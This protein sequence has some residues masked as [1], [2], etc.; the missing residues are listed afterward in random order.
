MLRWSRADD[1][2]A[3]GAVPR[4]TGSRRKGQAAEELTTP[5]K[6]CPHDTIPPISAE[7]WYVADKTFHIDHQIK[8]YVT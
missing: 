1:Q 3:P 4:S 5:P 7:E 6:W 8:L 2:A